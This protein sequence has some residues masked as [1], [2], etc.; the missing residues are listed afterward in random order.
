VVS[1]LLHT[2]EFNKDFYLQSELLVFP[3]L[4]DDCE[5]LEILYRQLDM[6]ALSNRLINPDPFEFR[7]LREYQPTDPLRNVN[8]KA[9]AVAQ[10][11]MVNIHAPTAAQ[12]LVLALN[13]ED[14]HAPAALHEECIRLAA[15][16]A[17]H[18]ISQDA[19]VGFYTNGRY[20]M[21]EYLGETGGD[22][23]TFL[24]VSSSPSQ[25]YDIYQCL[26]CVNLGVICTPLADYINRL[27]DKEQVYVFVSSY[28]GT[29]LL[30]AFNAL[31]ERGIEAFLIVPV[32]ADISLLET[33]KIAIWRV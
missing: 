14:M 8:F 26:A 4:L 20:L 16:L 25:L 28:H 32:Q 21:G 9:T 12:R 30:E 18:Y 3:K 10:R 6:A 22:K 31:G 15:T 11:L 24:P 13:L 2:T 17:E 19:G 27:V 23:S 33:D 29:D 7:G 1:N 5:Q